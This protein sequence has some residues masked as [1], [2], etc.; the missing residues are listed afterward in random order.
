MR[1]TPTKLNPTIQLIWNPNPSSEHPHLPPQIIP[2]S[3]STPTAS[4]HRNLHPTHIPP[5]HNTT[6]S[7]QHPSPPPIT[8]F[9][10]VLKNTWLLSHDIEHMVQLLTAQS[11][12]LIYERSPRMRRASWMSLGMMVTRLAWMAHKLVSSKRPTRYASMPPAKQGRQS[13]GT[14]S[15]P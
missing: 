12:Q 4:P 13:P 1:H 5:T 7:L 14:S 10:V 6:P 11:S 9:M 3:Q 2:P 8:R 15:P